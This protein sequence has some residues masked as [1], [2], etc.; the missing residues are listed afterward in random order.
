METFKAEGI[1]LQTNDFGDANRV[2]TIFTK[3]LG[4]IDA[5]AYGCRRTKNPMSGAMQ[6]FNH[7]AVELSSGNKVDT[8]RDADVLHFY[9]NLTAD[10]ERLAYASLLFEI[11]NRMTLPRQ[12]EIP[13]FDLLKNFLP[14][15]NERNPRV[16]A[17]IGICQFMKLSGVQ[18][19]FTECVH[20]GK[21]ISGDAFISLIDGGAV[22]PDCSTFSTETTTY[23]EFLRT[24]FETMLAFD[25]KAKLFFKSRQISAAEKFFLYYVQSVLGRE[26][27][28]VKFIRQIENF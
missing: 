3:E 7:V 25:G 22:C 24:T 21:K 4:K 23:P 8:I 20:C 15:L 28:S 2:V 13:V 5:N 1:I 9:G 6:M 26:L 10:L 17:L 11:V 12:Q 27:N 16:A 18:L 19:N 14:V